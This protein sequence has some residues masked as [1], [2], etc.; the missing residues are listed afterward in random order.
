[1]D[2]AVGSSYKDS[3]PFY[4]LCWRAD[5]DTGIS[6]VQVTKIANH[7]TCFA[8]ERVNRKD[9]GMSLVQ[10]TKTA[11]LGHAWTQ[12]TLVLFMPFKSELTRLFRSELTFLLKW[13][14]TCFLKS[15]IIIIII[16]IIDRFYIALIS[17]LEQTHCARM[18]LDISEKLFIARFFFFFKYPPNWCTYSADMA[19]ATWN[20]CRLGAFCVLHTTMHHV[21]SCKATYVRCMRV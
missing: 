19:G 8:E 10:V 2:V 14:L 17:S 18:W 13:K 4:L 7:S 5:K 9:T 12:V 3:T 15:E 6:L 21:T 20:C 11:Q 16:I 1:M